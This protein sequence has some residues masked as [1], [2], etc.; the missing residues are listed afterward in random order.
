MEMFKGAFIN[1]I[2]K[3]YRR[4]KVVVVVIISF[5]AIIIGQLFVFGL[6]SGWGLRTVSGFEFPG[7]VLSAFIETLLPLF[8]TLIAID[9]FSVEFNQNTLK[10]LLVRPVSRLKLFTAKISAIGVFIMG[11]LLLVMMLS[12]LSGLLFNPESFTFLGL[13]RTVISYLVTF[14]PVMV[15]ALIVVF[16]CNFVKS[17]T[18]VFFITIIMYIA[19]RGIG[20][21]FPKYSSLFVTSM[22]NWYNLWI[23]DKIHFLKLAREFLIM[24]GCAIMFFTAGFYLFDKKDL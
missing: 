3:M 12:I 7:M 18:T 10:I 24:I 6:R 17:G 5:L 22:F 16:L 15:F 4:K 21:V 9:I 11:I 23:A 14:I 20:I 1:E 13:Y 2:D 19:F 8:A